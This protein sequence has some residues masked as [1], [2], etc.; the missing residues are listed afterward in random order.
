MGWVTRLMLVSEVSAVAKEP[1]LTDGAPFEESGFECLLMGFAISGSGPAP[2]WHGNAR[3][4]MLVVCSPG[5][6]QA[7]CLERRPLMAN[8]IPF[9]CD[10]ERAIVIFGFIKKVGMREFDI[11]GDVPSVGT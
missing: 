5:S 3:T 6:R 10:D 11:S 1:S 8:R 7:L 2:W 9:L 4:R